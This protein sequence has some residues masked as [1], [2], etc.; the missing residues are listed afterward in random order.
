MTQNRSE[1][2]D[3]IIRFLSG[4]TNPEENHLLSSWVNESTENKSYFNSVRDIWLSTSQ[5]S[6][7]I[8]LSSF[9]QKDTDAEGTY[10]QGTTALNTWLKVAAILTMA[11]ISGTLVYK[12]F[13]GNQ[14]IPSGPIAVE[15]TLGS[16]AITTL[17]DGTKVWLNSG[18]KLVY[19][20]EYNNKTRKVQLT[21]E[22]YFSV[23]TNPSRP[24]IVQTGKINIKAVG[25]KFNVK[26]YPEDGSI[27]TTLESGKVIIEGKDNQNKDF[28]LKM[29][30][31]EVVT[32]L[33]DKTSVPKKSYRATEDKNAQTTGPVETEQH[34][35]KTEKV[36]TQL[37]TSWK[38]TRWII[39]EQKLGDLARDFERRYNIKIQFGSPAAEQFHFSGILENET[40]EQIMNI[41]RHTI[42]IKYKIEKGI[43]NI[44]QDNEL[45]K[46]FY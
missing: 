15:A 9:K 31:R 40:I 18:S 45:L 12:Q 17:P 26:A 13:S 3:I 23:V 24:F 21:G 29:K 34:L 42:P 35:I 28:V 25:T 22:A 7:S 32:Y 46:N 1:V 11:I 5:I 39:E 10:K 6:Q 16:R 20:N 14:R 37:F 36:N 41:M 43:I 8:S 44:E 27:V 2:E 38:D 4:E 30:P 33:K 19:D